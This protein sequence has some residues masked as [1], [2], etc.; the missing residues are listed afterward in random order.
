MRTVAEIRRANLEALVI[1]RGSLDA[2][3]TLAETSQIYLSQIRHQTIDGKTGKP[4]K[5]GG[6][7]ARRLEKGSSK[8]DGWMDHDHSNTSA[9]VNQ[10]AREPSGDQ[11]T[12]QID[13]YLDRLREEFLELGGAR[14]AR[15]GYTACVMALNKIQK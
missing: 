9:V 8:P 12:Q 2:V 10:N 6:I 3:A 11:L 15:K 5:M 4:R 13:F 7:I 14:A 1:E